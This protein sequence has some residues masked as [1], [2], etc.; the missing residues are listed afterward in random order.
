MYTKMLVGQGKQ[1]PQGGL[2]YLKSYHCFF[3]EKH[4]DQAKYKAWHTT[5]SQYTYSDTQLGYLNTLL[6]GSKD[7]MAK[8][9]TFMPKTIKKVPSPAWRERGSANK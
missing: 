7:A 6:E 2:D 5:F 4:L 8:L 9:K 3:L 1:M